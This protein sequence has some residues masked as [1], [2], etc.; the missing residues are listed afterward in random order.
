MTCLEHNH[1]RMIG[2]AMNTGTVSAQEHN[3]TY[4]RLTPQEW[5]AISSPYIQTGYKEDCFEIMRFDFNNDKVLATCKMTQYYVSKTDDLGF[6]LSFATATA[7]VSQL[8]II[9]AHASNDVWR[10]NYEA[11]LGKFSMQLNRAIRTPDEISLQ[12]WIVHKRLKPSQSQKDLIRAAYT[13][14]F[15]IVQGSFVGELTATFTDRADEIRF[16]IEAI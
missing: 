13:W 2:T 5:A 4:R 14:E 6:H 12:L 7:I 9:H 3:R 16:P 10:K 15:D 11:L 8:S 1:E